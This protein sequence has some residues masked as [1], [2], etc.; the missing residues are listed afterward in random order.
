MCIL[1]KGNNNTKHLPYTA[2]DLPYTALVRLILEYGVADWDPY[3]GQ[4]SA[5][6]QVQKRAANK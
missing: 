3:R 1:K 2:L 5:L 6:N 4:V